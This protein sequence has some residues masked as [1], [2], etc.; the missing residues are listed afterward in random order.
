MTRDVK[1]FKLTLLTFSFCRFKLSYSIWYLYCVSYASLWILLYRFSFS[2]WMVYILWKWR[3]VTWVELCPEFCGAFTSI[4]NQMFCF[5][6]GKCLKDAV[7]HGM[8]KIRF[9]YCEI[10]ERLPTIAF[11]V[12]SKW[13]VIEEF[14]KMME[15]V[16]F[17]SIG[18]LCD[19]NFRLR[20]NNISWDKS[21]NRAFRV[22]SS[23]KLNKTLP[24][25]KADCLVIRNRMK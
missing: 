21:E 9:F 23:G 17:H 14:I 1:E 24:T 13:P 19:I 25:Y 7:Q 15:W 22:H 6:C 8:P 16:T 18:K 3:R 20:L 2:G 10:G 12:L 5:C 11:N 4:T